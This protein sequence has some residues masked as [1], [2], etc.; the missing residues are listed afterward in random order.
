[1]SQIL[2]TIAGQTLRVSGEWLEVEF[3]DSVAKASDDNGIKANDRYEVGTDVTGDA[4]RPSAGG[5]TGATNSPET[6]TRR[7]DDLGSVQDGLKMSTDGQPN[8]GLST[9]CI[10]RPIEEGVTGGESAATKS[11]DG[12]RAAESPRF[13]SVHGA[14]EAHR[15]ATYGQLVTA[16]ETALISNS[17]TTPPD[18]TEP[19]T[20][21]VVPPASPVVPITAGPLSQSGPGGDRGTQIFDDRRRKNGEASPSPDRPCHVDAKS[22]QAAKEF[23]LRPF[24]QRP[25]LCGGYGQKHCGTCERAMRGS[26]AA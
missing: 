4:S 17:V 5:D 14:R 9:V 26:E 3:V 8:A 10:E 21:E 11:P 16:G 24:C 20:G 1:M 23:K 15:P 2:L 25:S 6:A 12:Q 22:K 7:L 19:R 18:V 13:E